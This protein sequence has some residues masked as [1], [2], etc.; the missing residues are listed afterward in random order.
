MNE[1]MDGWMDDYMNF[2]FHHGMCDIFS[3]GKGL[4]RDRAM[5]ASD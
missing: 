1:W 4:L 5:L 2:L 3:G